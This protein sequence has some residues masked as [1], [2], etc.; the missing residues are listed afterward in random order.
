[1]PTREETDDQVEL[2]A[3]H[4]R[5]LARYLKQ[6]AALSSTYVPLSIANGIDEERNNILQVKKILR[7]WGVDVKDH[8]HDAPQSEA[9]SS[10][11]WVQPVVRLDLPTGIREAQVQFFQRISTL[12]WEFHA[13][14][15]KVAY[16][17]KMEQRGGSTHA[18]RLRD[19]MMD[20]EDKLWSI[21][22]VGI[23]T[24]ISKSHILVS[25][26]AYQKLKSFYKDVLIALDQ[27]LVQLLEQDV[28]SDTWVRFHNEAL[29]GELVT[30]IE[31]TLHM[32]A[33]DMS[34]AQP[35]A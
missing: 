16:Y 12:L 34:L 31:Q 24:E 3:I 27:E 1:M 28:D 33:K 20:Y 4:R 17:K 21:V 32:L 5:N 23:Q 15:A 14:I 7:D 2:L 6:Q 18:S 11:N 8:P 10:Q 13:L 22:I 9:G 25:S 35:S 29:K 30:E 26:L 19:A